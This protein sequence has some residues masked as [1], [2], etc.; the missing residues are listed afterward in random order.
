MRLLLAAATAVVATLA[1][2]GLPVAAAQAAP[3][4]FTHP[5]VLVSRP[6]LDFVKARV[7]AG[8][9]P[10]LNA[11]NQMMSSRYASLSRVPAPRAT[12]ECG[13]TS[14][15]NNGCTDEREDAIAAYTDALAWY[16]TGNAADRLGRLGVA[17]RRRD[18]PLHLRHLAQPGS[19]R[20]HAAQRLPPG[21]HRRRLAH[22]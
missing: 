16:I 15:P 9:Q 8:E 10:W 3:A 20:H 17:T 19:L 21:G 18:H 4:T 22:G 5:G 2:L 7:Q 1:P 12:V 13:P 6:Q 11:Y 14:N